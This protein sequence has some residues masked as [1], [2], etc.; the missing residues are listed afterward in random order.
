MVL[1]CVVWCHVLCMVWSR[2]SFFFGLVWSEWYLRAINSQL[3]AL[4]CPY[5]FHNA[6]EMDSKYVFQN[7]SWTTLPRQVILFS[8]S[9]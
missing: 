3:F 9:F 8:I 2:V 7:S 4:L 1:G 5:T 6:P